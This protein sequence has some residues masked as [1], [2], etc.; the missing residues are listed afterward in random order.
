VTRICYLLFAL[1]LPFCISSQNLIGSNS[2]NITEGGYFITYSVGESIIGYVKDE[3]SSALIGVQ[4]PLYENMYGLPSLTY[5][6]ISANPTQIDADGASTSSITVSLK[7]GDN[8]A[9]PWGGETVEIIPTLGTMTSVTDNNNGTYAAT[10]TSS[11]AP[12]TSTIN[13]E[14]NGFQGSNTAEVD[15]LADCVDVPEDVDIPD[16]DLG[17]QTIIARKT[18]STGGSVMAGNEV[19]LVSGTSITLTAGFAVQ[20]GALF[21]ARIDNNLARIANCE[22]II[23]PPIVFEDHNNIIQENLELYPNPSTGE[24]NLQFNLEN[25]SMV[26]LRVYDFMGKLI[27]SFKEG[28]Q[29]YSGLN[30][31][32]LNLSLLKGGVYTIQVATKEWVASKSLV[33]VKN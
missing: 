25:A 4:Q 26:T 12:G 28:T 19:T 16:G 2:N 1:G 7:D 29:Y 27:Q 9:I 24:V 13:F 3:S 32:E 21:S 18:I 20:P 30:A 23:A 5:S 11:T 31:E 15:F 14:V 33:I 8:E 17:S 6:T 22:D 10:L